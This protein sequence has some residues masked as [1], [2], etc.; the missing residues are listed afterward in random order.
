[1]ESFFLGAIAGAVFIIIVARFPEFTGRSPLTKEIRRARTLEEAGRLYMR[2]AVGTGDEVI[3]FEKVSEL[4]NQDLAKVQTFANCMMIYHDTPIRKHKERVLLEALRF[5]ED[6][7][8][9]ETIRGFASE[10][11][12]ST[13]FWTIFLQTCGPKVLIV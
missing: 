9:I 5:I 4:F 8:Q 2:A 11:R 10:L 6:E 13:E 12:A 7:D 3:A 1:V